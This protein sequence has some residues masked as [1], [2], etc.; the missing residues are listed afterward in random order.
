MTCAPLSLSPAPLPPPSPAPLGH[1]LP[2]AGEGQQ[3]TALR[4]GSF[5]SGEGFTQSGVSSP[6]ARLR[7]RDWGR[8]WLLA[9]LLFFTLPAQSAIETDH[10]T[11]ES[12]RQRFYQL[13]RELRCPKCQNQDIADS[14]APIAA[15]LRR[16]IRRLLNEGQSNEQITAHMVSRYGEFVRYK[17]ALN[18]H[19]VLLWF[20]PG[21]LLLLGFAVLAVLIIRRKRALSQS[22]P[23]SAAEQAR[24]AALLKGKADA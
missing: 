1:P 17:P 18:Q 19:T 15:D 6:L 16:E 11:D 2:Q 4:A 5:T 9:L 23:L 12:K 7:E 20:G 14:N 24:L 8:G 10:L 21:V 13:T 3:G 22:A